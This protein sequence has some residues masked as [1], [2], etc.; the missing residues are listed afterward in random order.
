MIDIAY[1]DNAEF[2]K[3]I[4][5]SRAGHIFANAGRQIYR[6]NG[7]SDYLLFYVA[8]GSETFFLGG[9]K[10]RAVPGS[11][12]VFAP[13]EAQHHICENEGTSEFYYVH[14]ECSPE[15]IS[16]HFPAKTS[17]VYN[18]LFDEDLSAHFQAILHELQLEEPFCHEIAVTR[19]E[20]V[21]LH[22][23]RAVTERKS[24]LSSAQIKEVHKIIH[25]INTTWKEQYSLDDYAGEFSLSKYHFSHIFKRYTGFSPMAYRN[26]LR[27][28]YAKGMLEKTDMSIAEIAE[29][30]G[31]SGQQYFCEAFKERYNISPSDYR[32]RYYSG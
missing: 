16:S 32:K 11:F 17:T 27:L 9:K 18:T 13:G 10:K 15:V 14:F 8:S 24:N 29:N 22:L 3:N 30:V 12:I 28:R 6:P 1:C 23:R 19:L 5:V 20:E 2:Y 7:R 31:F 21:F 25:R 4:R 26:R